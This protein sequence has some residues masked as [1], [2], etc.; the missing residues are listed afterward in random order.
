M[1]ES[2]RDSSELQQLL[3]LPDQEVTQNDKDIEILDKVFEVMDLDDN[4][5]IN[6]KEFIAFFLI[7]ECQ[8]VIDDNLSQVNN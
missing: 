1:I 6:K 2:A 8:Q 4:K 3:S 5:R 7:H